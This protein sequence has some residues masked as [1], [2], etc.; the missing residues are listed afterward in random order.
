VDDTAADDAARYS[1]TPRMD[2]LAADGVKLTAYYAQSS[3]TPTRASLL[4]GKYASRT[5]LAHDTIGE[6][7]FFSHSL[8]SPSFSG[9]RARWFTR[10]G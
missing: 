9:G 4:T 6:G 2:A 3:C 8:V 5:G 7:Y 1:A 10:Q